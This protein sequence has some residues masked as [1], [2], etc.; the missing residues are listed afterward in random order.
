MRRGS[1][2]GGLG[3]LYVGVM[4]EIHRDDMGTVQ[5]LYN[6]YVGVIEITYGAYRGYIGFES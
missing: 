3:V 6:D 5:A 2:E 4:Q 1:Y